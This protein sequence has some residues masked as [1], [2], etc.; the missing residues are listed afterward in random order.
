MVLHLK[1]PCAISRKIFLHGT[2]Q[3]WSWPASQWACT[4]GQ[5]FHPLALWRCFISCN[6]KMNYKNKKES[7]KHYEMKNTWGIN[8]NRE[9][10]TRYIKQSEKGSPR[11]RQ[12]GQTTAP[13]K[14]ISKKSKSK[15][16]K[17]NPGPLL[18]NRLKG[19]QDCAIEDWAMK[20]FQPTYLTACCSHSKLGEVKNERLYNVVPGLSL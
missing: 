5:Q 9:M 20:L 15:Q 13:E 17:D 6:Q 3:T 12:T 4:V 18:G 8:E 10:K 14:Q 19:H 16:D 1:E 11:K 7:P 2:S